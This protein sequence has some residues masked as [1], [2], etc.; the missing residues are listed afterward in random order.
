[1]SKMIG[2]LS[3]K[4]LSN[5]ITPIVQ[6]ARGNNLRISRME[7][8]ANNNLT[9]TNMTDT[10]FDDEE[11][12]EDDDNSDSRMDSGSDASSQSSH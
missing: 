1:M 11:D 4:S 12:Y 2:V 8:E 10:A 5:A 3:A 6:S 9:P 7:S